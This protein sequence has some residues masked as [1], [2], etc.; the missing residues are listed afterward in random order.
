MQAVECLTAAYRKHVRRAAVRPSK[1][2]SPNLRS[3]GAGKALRTHPFDR[4][5]QDIGGWDADISE[6]AI[7]VY[8][9]RLRYELDLGDVRI[10]TI[11]GIGY[12]LDG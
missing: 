2:S 11:Y 5:F 3:W 7:E 9:S 4:L 10:R 1:D 8:V 12:R 6:N